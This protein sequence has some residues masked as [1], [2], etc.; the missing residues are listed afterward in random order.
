M[1][2]GIATKTYGVTLVDQEHVEISK[3]NKNYNQKQ[4]FDL[5]S[6]FVSELFT[7]KDSEDAIKN[8]SNIIVLSLKL[9]NNNRQNMI[10][11]K[12]G[13]NS[14]FE[15][16]SEHRNKSNQ[17]TKNPF[18]KYGKILE[19]LH[20]IIA[21]CP[22]LPINEKLEYCNIERFFIKSVLKELALIA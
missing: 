4:K 14:F 1:S 18:M 17:K 6:I 5:L 20:S 19:I 10:M 2:S 3:S 12:Q 11:S 13:G 22:D 21:N 9:F 7:H 8:I 15:S 16:I